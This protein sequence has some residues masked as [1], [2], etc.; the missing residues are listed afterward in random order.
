MAVVTP[1][2]KHD[3]SERWQTFRKAEMTIASQQYN[4]PQWHQGREYYCFWGMLVDEAKVE[5]HLISLKQHLK[6]YLV[7]D[8]LKQAHITLYAAGFVCQ[9]ERYQDDV[10][11]AKLA[12]QETALRNLQL[13]RFSITTSHVNS[14]AGAP[15]IEI[16][17]KQSTLQ[18]IH[19]TLR[20]ISGADRDSEFVPHITIGLYRDTFSTI[21]IAEI[22]QQPPNLML[23]IECKRL[24]LLAYAANDIRSPLICLREINLS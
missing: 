11:E 8:N 9:R 24:C 14:F 18:K 2:V 3:F 6:N 13:S 12:Q 21:E 5:N 10:S 19:Q 1:S 23:S 16:I 4:W 7:A 15:F 22:L 20:N 17:D